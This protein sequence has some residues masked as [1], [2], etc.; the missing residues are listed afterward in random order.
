MK[1]E[2]KEKLR[3]KCIENNVHLPG[4]VAIETIFEE[5]EHF[6]NCNIDVFIKELMQKEPY[7][8]KAPLERKKA[9]ISA[10]MH[11]GA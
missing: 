6:K 7:Y 10:S 1:D 4:L 5:S 11:Q 2:I 8:F 9:P 3:K